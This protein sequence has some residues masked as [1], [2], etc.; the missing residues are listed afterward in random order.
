[1]SNK[2]SA[3]RGPTPHGDAPIVRLRT[4][5]VVARIVEAI[6]CTRLGRARGRWHREI[7]I[8]AGFAEDVELVVD[9]A[10]AA[11]GSGIVQRPVAVDEGIGY[12][13]GRAVACK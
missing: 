6:D 8:A 1:M 5:R 4:F 10:T 13:A 11:V 3:G 7:G 12:R 9:A 2:E